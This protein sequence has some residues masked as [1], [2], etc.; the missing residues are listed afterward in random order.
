MSFYHRVIDLFQ[1]SLKKLAEKKG[2]TLNQN[3]QDIDFIKTVLI[4]GQVLDVIPSFL[5]SF[6]PP[7][8]PPPRSAL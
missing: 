4:G 3:A 5:P 8:P 7:S 6:L 1:P 2:V